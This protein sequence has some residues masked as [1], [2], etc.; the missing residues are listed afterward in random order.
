MALVPFF[1]KDSATQFPITLNFEEDV[2]EGDSIASC[3]C[4]ARERR[5]EEDATETVLVT[6]EG[7]VNMSTSEVTVETMGG[8]VGK[9]YEIFFALTLGSDITP[10][11][12][13]A[14]LYIDR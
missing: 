14:I 5:T 1:R 9:F 12:Y 11:P 7:D 8:V 13:R 2:P 4:S 6:T 3:V 10:P